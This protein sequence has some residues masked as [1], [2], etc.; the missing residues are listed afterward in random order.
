MPF[1]HK[2]KKCK[3]D[4]YVYISEVSV[5]KES[6]NI[7]QKLFNKV[8]KKAKEDKCQKII[9]LTGKKKNHDKIEKKLILK[10]GFKKIRDVKN[11]EAYPNYF[12][13]DHS[14]WGRDVKTISW[15]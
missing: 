1:I 11:W 14:L 6:S 8:L 3:D 2:I 9:W 4:K 15:K 7:L 12:V 13:P 10:N 5:K